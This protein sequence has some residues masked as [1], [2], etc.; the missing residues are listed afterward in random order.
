MVIEEGLPGPLPPPDGYNTQVAVTQ[1][2]PLAAHFNGP[3]QICAVSVR[4]NSG[5]GT[6]TSVLQKIVLVLIS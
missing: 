3:P 4:K 2:P 5:G 6:E 1:P